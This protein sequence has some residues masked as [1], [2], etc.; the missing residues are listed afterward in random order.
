M[1]NDIMRKSKQDIK[2]K[3]LW[4]EIRDHKLLLDED[5]SPPQIV[6]QP[7]KIFDFIT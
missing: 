4:E 5:N 6:L 7:M 1:T 2:M 3:R